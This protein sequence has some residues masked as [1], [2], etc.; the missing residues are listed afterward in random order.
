[1]KLN[2]YETHGNRKASVSFM[3]TFSSTPN[4]LPNQL[5]TKQRTETDLSTFFIILI[6]QSRTQI[7][8]IKK[9]EKEIR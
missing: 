5:D 3:S 2:F 4:F 6:R 8:M 9:M 1:M 7:Q